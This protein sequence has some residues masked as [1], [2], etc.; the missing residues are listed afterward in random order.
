[1]A[2]SEIQIVTY[3]SRGVAAEIRYEVLANGTRG[4]QWLSAAN[5]IDGNGSLSDEDLAAVSQL[6]G[7][8]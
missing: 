8:G 2:K 5:W 3:Q 7:L 4:V 6:L 1:M